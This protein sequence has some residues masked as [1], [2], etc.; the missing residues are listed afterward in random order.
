MFSMRLVIST[1]GQGSYRRL[2]HPPGIHL[3]GVCIVTANAPFDIPQF[4]K[5]KLSCEICLRPIKVILG[6]WPMLLSLVPDDRS[7]IAPILPFGGSRER[8]P[9][10]KTTTAY[11]HFIHAN[12]SW[13]PLYFSRRSIVQMPTNVN[14]FICG[15]SPLRR[16]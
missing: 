2:R 8:G 12:S 6:L 1:S 7:K 4:A 10:L 13:K 16:P 15:T 3:R 11:G 9:L 14:R 5:A